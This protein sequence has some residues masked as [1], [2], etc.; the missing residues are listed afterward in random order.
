MLKCLEDVRHVGRSIG[1]GTLTGI[2]IGTGAAKVSM[3]FGVAQFECECWMFWDVFT[4]F[5]RDLCK[6]LSEVKHN[7]H[8]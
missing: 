5:G 6:Y 8:L 4:F 3:V 2:R 7:S 1:I